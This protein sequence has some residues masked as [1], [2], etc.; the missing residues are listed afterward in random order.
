M[1]WITGV[2]INNYSAFSKSETIFISQGQHLLTYGE[3][4]SSKSLL[5]T[6]EAI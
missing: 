1:K 5:Y 4:G 6:N 2:T 3:N